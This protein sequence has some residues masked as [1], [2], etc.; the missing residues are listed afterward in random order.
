MKIFP[1]EY[2]CLLV[3]MFFK[4]FHLIRIVIKINL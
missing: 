1:L 2:I 3:L 4:F